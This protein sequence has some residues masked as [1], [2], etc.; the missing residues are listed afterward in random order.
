M[1]YMLRVFQIFFMLMLSATAIAQQ[2]FE[3]SI[4]LSILNKHT[5]ESGS[6]EWKVK[7]PD[8]YMGFSTHAG[9]ENLRY[10]I[11]IKNGNAFLLSE[12]HGHGTVH[13]IDLSAAKASQGDIMASR[14]VKTEETSIIAGQ[15]ARKI[16]IY[17]NKT[18]TVC[19]VSEDHL[20][21]ALQIPSVL[22]RTG[23]M[24]AMQRNNINGFPLEIITMD[25]SGEIIYS[26]SVTAILPSII[27]ADSFE[28]P[29]HYQ[30]VK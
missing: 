11:L 19:W 4:M 20:L 2:A 16:L 1:M 24:G 7:N 14:V 3:G 13:D 5:G 18:S 17:G 27:S 21:A 29:P 15:K 26:Q 6:V 25:E 22:S 9:N 23:V 12:V 10:A 28:L 8:H 30:R